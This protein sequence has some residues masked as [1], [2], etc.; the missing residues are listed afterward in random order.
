MLKPIAALLLTAAAFASSPAMAADPAKWDINNPPA[1]T[2]RQIPIDV[3]EGSWMDVDVSPDGRTI[4]FTL[5]GDIY[6]MPIGGGTPTRIAEGLAYEANPRFSPDGQRIAFTSDRAGADNIWVMNVDGSNKQQI[7]NEDF[8]TLNQPSWSPDGQFLV[9]RK[10]F[11]TWRSLGTGEIWLYHISGGSGVPLVKRASEALQKELGDPFFAPDGKRVYYT[12]NVSAGPIFEYA[13]DSNSNLFNIEAIDLATGKV[14]TIVAGAGGAVRPTPSPDGR[15]IAF[16]RRERTG[17]KLFVKDL[18]SGAEHKIYDALDRDQ[19]EGWAVQGTYPN[20]A[21]TPDSRAILFWA[22][23][24]LNRLPVEGG[25]AS[26]IPFHVADTRGAVQPFHPVVDVAPDRFAARM[27]RFVQVSPDGRS[28]AFESLGRLWVQPLAGGAARRLT[29]DSDN[30]RE[31]HPAWSR[32]GRSIVFVRWNDTDLGSIRVIPATGGKARVVTANPGHYASPVF[33]PDGQTIVFENG[34]G[35]GLVSDRWSVESGVYK[36]NAAGGTPALVLA[37]ARQPQFGAASDRLFVRLGS[38]KAQLASVDMTGGA[39]RIHAS[40]E[41]VRDWSVSP[42]GRTLLFRQNGEAFAMPLPPGPQ[43]VGA[44]PMAGALPVVRLSNGG[45]EWPHWSNN[46]Q[47]IHWSVGPT[48]YS[49][50]TAALF[51]AAP[52]RST[53]TPPVSGQSI[54]RDIAADKPRGRLALVNARVVT[55]AGADGGII[56]RATILVDGDRIAAIGAGVAIPAGTRTID[57]AGKT[58]IPGL[59]D[60][61]AHGPQGED[62]LIP[63][64]NWSTIANLALGTTTIHDPSNNSTTVYAASEYQRAGLL[65]APRIF[66]AGEPI[67]GARAAGIYAKIDNLDDALAQV[68]RHKAEGGQ[69]VKNYNQPRR[70]ARQMIVAAGRQEGMQV[71]VEGGSLFGL[72][73]AHIIDGNA[74]LEH[75]IPLDVFYDDMLQFIPKTGVNYTPTLIVTFGGMTGEIY[76]RQATNLFEQPLLVAHTPPAILAAN[77][78]RPMAPDDQFADAANAREAGRLAE[79]GVL[80]SIGAHGQ[81]AGIGPH[82]E[83]W[84]FVRGGMTPVQALAAGTINAARSLGMDKDIGSLEAGKL[85]DLVVLDADPVANIRNSEKVTQVMLGGRLYDAATMDEIAPAVVKRAPHWWVADRQ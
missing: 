21:F 26:D 66:S 32:D 63:Q 57:L 59:V 11:T 56:D 5:L 1:A 38:G 46:G 78:R 39:Q 68:R 76:W 74:T 53:Y 23:G 60:A 18:Q 52:G 17:S 45:A 36:V 70:M 3:R 71:V 29:A 13:Q 15:K 85:A 61:H 8:R 28:V 33:A 80:V 12:R 27:A 22:G 47:R 62:D 58:V 4:A 2:I 48:V 72:D 73:I 40:G 54:T 51:P 84:S 16:I 41:L 55:M 10:H 30:A 49:A 35:G 67:Y 42:D 75:N 37:G 34:G 83:L 6:T 65:L 81:Q 20:L 14:E 64:Q 50:A 44:D 69:S 79:R 25:R 82:W 31:L 19:Q 43:D 77:L 9:A 7:T 24:K